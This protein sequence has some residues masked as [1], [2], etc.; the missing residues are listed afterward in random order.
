MGKCVLKS[1]YIDYKVSVIEEM[2]E[3]IYEKYEDNYNK[4]IKTEYGKIKEYK[5]LEKMLV[6]ELYIINKIQGSDTLEGKT[7]FYYILLNDCLIH[8]DD[9]SFNIS[10]F[11]G[12]VR[13]NIK[14]IKSDIE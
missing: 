2:V 8:Y 5:R 10:W 11:K 13:G 3:D 6:N 12:R 7:Y 1:E 4:G 9:L 14:L